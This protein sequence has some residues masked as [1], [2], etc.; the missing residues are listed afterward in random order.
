[1]ERPRNGD[2]MNADVNFDD[3][4]ARVLTLDLL[5]HPLFLRVGAISIGNL[6]IFRKQFHL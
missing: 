3:E 6:A 5:V 4:E 1:M 2:L